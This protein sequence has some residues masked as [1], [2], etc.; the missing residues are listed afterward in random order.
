MAETGKMLA[1]IGASG[2][3]KVV[4][5]IAERNGYGTIVFLD[6]NE[7]LDACG[8]YRVVGRTKEAA[9]FAKRGYDVIVAIG[10]GRIRQRMQ[11][12][13]EA[14]GIVCPTMVHPMAVLA[15]DVHL[16]SG[17]VV[18]AMA[19]V[20]AGSRIG[21]GCIINTCASVDHDC[22]IGD[23][24][25]VAVGA[26]LAGAVSAGRLTWIGAGAVVSNNISVCGDCMIGAGAAVVRDIEESGTYVGVPAKKR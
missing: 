6:D 12:E 24:V 16:K 20:N 26:H 13:L 18:M 17:T 2:H 1:V 9:A 21:K 4:A 14:E 23:Y 8:K 5:D 22:S 11:E 7:E 10:N 3:G 15:A 19:V 25:H